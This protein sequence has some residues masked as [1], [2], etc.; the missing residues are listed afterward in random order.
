MSAICFIAVC[1]GFILAGVR[2]GFE[3]GVLM[4]G[5]RSNV[6]DIA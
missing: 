4:P 2:N 3:H 1:A 6:G 5:V